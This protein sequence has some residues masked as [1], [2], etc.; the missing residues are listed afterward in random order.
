MSLNYIHLWKELLEGL[1]CMIYK[2]LFVFVSSHAYLLFEG[3]CF[4]IFCHYIMQRLDADVD[5]ATELVL[6]H[7]N[8]QTTQSH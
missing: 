6:D 3:A 4:G 7:A 5:D 1:N 2:V 8:T